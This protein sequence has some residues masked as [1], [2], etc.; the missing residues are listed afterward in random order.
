MVKRKS[1]KR[2]PKQTPGI[3]SIKSDPKDDFMFAAS[4]YFDSVF[5][6]MSAEYH[7][8]KYKSIKGADIENHYNNYIRD[9]RLALSSAFTFFEAYCN[10]TAYGHAHAHRKKLPQA[11]LDILE[12]LETGLDQQGNIVRKVK[13]YP[14]E[15][16]FLFLVKFLSGKSFDAGSKLWTNFREVKSLRDSW[17]HPKPPFYTS[18]LTLEQVKKTIVTVRAVLVELSRLMGL[19]HALWMKPFDEIYEDYKPNAPKGI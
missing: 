16:R 2:P 3:A 4:T 13:Y 6:Y 15:S 17:I 9:A 12:S 19:E 10:Q 11:E 8:K 1:E 14:I 7:Q 18:D 5:L